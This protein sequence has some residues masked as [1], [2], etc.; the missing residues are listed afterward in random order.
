MA[1]VYTG[2]IH[3]L[4]NPLKTKLVAEWYGFLT[5]KYVVWRQ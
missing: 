4:F 1:L 2:E 3:Y 5:W